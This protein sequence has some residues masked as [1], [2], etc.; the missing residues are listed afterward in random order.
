MCQSCKHFVSNESDK[1][2]DF[3]LTVTVIY[4]R[5]MYKLSEET[6]DFRVRIRAKKKSKMTLRQFYRLQACFQHVSIRVKDE[7]FFILV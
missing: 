4:Y 3:S 7:A 1:I 6:V 5:L 2:R